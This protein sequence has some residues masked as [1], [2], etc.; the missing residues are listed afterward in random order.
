MVNVSKYYQDVDLNAR[1]LAAKPHELTTMLLERVQ[2]DLKIARIAIE[3]QE[4]AIKCKHIA[5]A[6]DILSHLESSLNRDADPAL[7]DKLSTHYD[8]LCTQLVAVNAC[9]DLDKLTTCEQ[10]VTNIVTWWKKMIEVLETEV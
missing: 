8:Y 9:N 3:N 6:I 1:V 10:K 5:S 2:S 4:I 7:C